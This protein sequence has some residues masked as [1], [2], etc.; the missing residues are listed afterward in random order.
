MIRYSDLI[1]RRDTNDPLVPCILYARC[2]SK[3]GERTTNLL[4]HPYLC[5]FECLRYFD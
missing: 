3:G 2:M 1:R 5:T 4:G